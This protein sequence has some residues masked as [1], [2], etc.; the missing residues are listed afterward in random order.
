MERIA[1]GPPF[2]ATVVA[3][4][5]TAK[6]WQTS[7]T[8][9]RALYDSRGMM[10]PA[11]IRTNEDWYQHQGYRIIARVDKQYTWEHPLSGEVIA[12]P[13][14]I[15]TKDLGQDLNQCSCPLTAVDSQDSTPIAAMVPPKKRG[16]RQHDA[17][18]AARHQEFDHALCEVRDNT[19]VPVPGVKKKKCVNCKE[20]TMTRGIG[21]ECAQVHGPLPLECITC[22]KLRIRQESSGLF[23]HQVDGCKS[24]RLHVV[25]WP[26]YAEEDE[27][28]VDGGVADPIAY[29]GYPYGPKDLTCEACR[30]LPDRKRCDVDPVLGIGCSACME[31][32]DKLHRAGGSASNTTTNKNTELFRCVCT[33]TNGDGDT[34]RV[35]LRKRPKPRQNTPLWFRRACVR[36][37][38]RRNENKPDTPCDWTGSRNTW[39]DACKQCSDDHRVCLDN[40]VLKGIIPPNVG[41]NVPTPYSWKVLKIQA[42]KYDETRSA[43]S[44]R[45]S[46]LSCIE[47]RGHCRVPDDTPRWAC[48]RCAQH[49]LVCRDVFGNTYD[50]WDL[51]K[52]G[53]GQ[54]VPFR[55][56]QRCHEKGRNCDLQRPCDSCVNHKEGSLCDPLPQG[57]TSNCIGRLNYQQPEGEGNADTNEQR[58]LSGR[59]GILYYLALGYGPG[60]VDDVKDGSQIEH[61][62]GPLS[63]CHAHPNLTTSRQCAAIFHELR[64]IRN[65]FLPKHVPPH[66]GLIGPEDAIPPA[67][68]PLN[69]VDT[70]SLTVEQL[71]EM[72]R[73]SWPNIQPPNHYRDGDSWGNSDG[74]SDHG[75]NDDNEED[76]NDDDDDGEDDDDDVDDDDDDDDDNGKPSRKRRKSSRRPSKKKR[77]N[78]P[79]PKFNKPRPT[80]EDIQRATAEIKI[81]R[82]PVDDTREE[83]TGDRGRIE[84]RNETE[85]ENGKENGVEDQD[86]DQGGHGGQLGDEQGGQHGDDTASNHRQKSGEMQVSP[87]NTRQDS[88]GPQWGRLFPHW[89]FTSRESNALATN[90]WKDTSQD[91][92]VGLKVCMEPRQ[93]NDFV[94]GRYAADVS[95]CWPAAQDDTREDH[96]VC[97]DCSKIS[98]GHIVKDFT[99]KIMD[100]RLYL[101]EPCA[102]QAEKPE[103]KEH[104]TT[105]KSKNLKDLGVR[106]LWGG[107]AELAVD[108]DETEEELLPITGCDCGSKL[109]Q[110]TMCVCHRDV[111]S[112]QVLSR[113][114]AMGDWIPP[115]YE[116]EGGTV[117]VP[118]P[119]CVVR[120]KSRA[121]V[122]AAP[123][124][125]HRARRTSAWVCVV[126]VGLV[127]DPARQAIIPGW[128]SWFHE[129]YGPTDWPKF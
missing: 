118:C 117:R 127:I 125:S 16:T 18:A 53:F 77:K 106:K 32:D 24:D 55:T 68:G 107:T 42:P 29:A 43:T 129:G 78:R 12:M 85:D 116:E 105:R 8:G 76:E 7:E 91:T 40:S 102:D 82:A 34:C 57:N 94:C 59:P 84:D 74:G 25:F 100:M 88:S 37:D 6:A 38:R 9:L 81:R 65:T 19:K 62:V 93:T 3:I 48:T 80:F 63:K 30:D 41:C 67:R 113:I 64:A 49:G 47:G 72:L 73:T 114:Q 21:R 51:S 126:C 56:C 103:G 121:T 89:K 86:G 39:D 128:E 97:E 115:A 36:C 31:E 111:C 71:R 27:E 13:G 22:S 124:A 28:P 123:D 2:N 4:D 110:Q 54:L 5:T 96:G 1:A 46:C 23:K 108:L 45:S 99:G 120:R 44:W 61:W 87:P 101:C 104:Q 75:G 58:A 79:K 17:S 90:P 26:R 20:H 122:N 98:A 52:I 112:Q 50:V 35:A 92:E 11:V 95:L 83:E 70:Q 109:F 66:R 60:G 15:Q 14:V 33:Y 69:N 119:M 10:R